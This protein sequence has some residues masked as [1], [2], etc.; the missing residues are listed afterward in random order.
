MR[1]ADNTSLVSDGAQ[2]PRPQDA[3]RSSRL[4]LEDRNGSHPKGSSNSGG[5]SLTH[6]GLKWPL[7]TN[8]YFIDTTVSVRRERWTWLLPRSRSSCYSASLPFRLASMVCLSHSRLALPL[9]S[10]AFVPAKGVP[11]TN[12]A[13]RWR[14]KHGVAYTQ[15]ASTLTRLD[16]VSPA[17]SFAASASRRKQVRSS[18]KTN[19]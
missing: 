16:C 1:R 18:T 10:S 8:F 7:K 5:M 6:T 19:F 13:A 17:S 15:S 4:Q 2:L 9:V 11:S 14:H 3:E 12:L